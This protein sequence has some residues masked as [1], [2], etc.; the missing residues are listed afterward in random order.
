MLSSLSCA[1]RAHL[2][3]ASGHAALLLLF[4]LFMVINEK[5]F[6]RGNLGEIFR[7]CFQGRYMMLLMVSPAA[8]V[9]LFCMV[10]CEVALSRLQSIFAI[11]CGV[12]YND[13]FAQG[14]NFF[15]SVWHFPHGNNTEASRH[16]ARSTDVFHVLLR[17]VAHVRCS[18]SVQG[19]MCI[20]LVWTPSGTL[21]AM[22]CCSSTL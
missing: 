11:Y 20:H 7:M 17:S 2:H 9:F 19:M 12:V 1:A 3:V 22:T 13:L 18:V 6:M 10:P 8:N 5:K 14:T 16:G 4:S 15:G 21:P